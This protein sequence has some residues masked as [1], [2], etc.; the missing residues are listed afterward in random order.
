MTED[1]KSKTISGMLWSAVQRFGTMVISFIGNILNH[2]KNIH[3][4]I[5]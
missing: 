2:L 1:L 4:N 3:L 5:L